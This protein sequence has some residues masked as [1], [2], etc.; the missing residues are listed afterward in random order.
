M[1]SQTARSGD[2]HSKVP[3]RRVPRL[4]I[5][6]LRLIWGASRRDFIV[7]GVMQLIGGV[8]TAT[9]L[10]VVRNALTVLMNTAQ[11]HSR[12][13]SVLPALGL[14]VAVNLLMTFTSGLQA[15][16]Q[17][18]ISELVGQ[19]TT[20]RILH[21]AGS[22]DLAAY[23][24]PSFYDRLQRASVGAGFRPWQ[25]TLAV[26]GTLHSA[27]AVLALIAALF[28]LTPV[29]VPLT[30][31]IFVPLWLA[32]TFSSRSMYQFLFDVA[33][34]DRRRAYIRKLMIERENAK[35][36]RVYAL[37]AYLRRLNALLSQER[38][39]SLRKVARSRTLAILG[40]SVST[41]L[42][43]ALMLGMLV[44]LVSNNWL[45]LASASA[46]ALAIFQLGGAISG[47]VAGAGQISENALYIEDYLTFLDV[48]V[49]AERA[50]LP[51]PPTGFDRLRV[52]HVDFRYQG[53][54]VKAL[55]D[56][57]LE[58]GRGQIVAV[59]GENGSGKTTLA[60][61]LCGLY[62]PDA[63]RIL[64]DGIDIS[65]TDASFVRNSTSIV[66]QDFVRY[67]F[68]A[69]ENIGMGRVESIAD[70]AAIA[71][72]AAKADADGFVEGL[73]MGYDTQLGRL[74]E[75]GEELSEGQWQRIALA[76]AFFRDA[77][78]VIL[79]EPT[80]D[81]DARAEHALFA[82]VK[83][84]FTGRTVLLISH[85]LS[86]VRSADRIFVLKQ[87]RIVESGTHTELIRNDGLY[88]ELFRLQ[89]AGYIRAEAAL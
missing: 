45:N 14:L 11:A 27:I 35:E 8:V 53:S 2:A 23:D 51:P 66:F 4:V 31:P 63:G 58:I 19:L 33:T 60:K 61:L 80:A 79:D 25:M 44:Y 73:P 59:V 67:M 42:L 50:S 36:V 10:L 26:L 21:A 18:V 74:F 75:G 20:D 57:S 87:G 24:T 62:R 43:I 28:L 52:S 86:G 71:R 5:R 1:N 54:D 39:A 82:A 15:Q 17:Q 89:E 41:S 81:L 64:W 70:Q 65:E 72:A 69:G 78:F 83:S 9:S 29:L 32:S 76:R 49:V 37:A 16:R 22:A 6:S 3:M 77:P 85:R 38:I 56:V 30:L 55:A 84:L 12:P 7:V 13:G 46:A 68:T 47:L 48:H 40:G 88:A 34:L